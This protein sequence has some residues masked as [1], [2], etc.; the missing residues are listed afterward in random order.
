MSNF[1][2]PPAHTEQDGPMIPIQE[3]NA[4]LE[5][6]D[7]QTAQWFRA[8]YAETCRICVE[9]PASRQLMLTMLD[10]LMGTLKAGGD[11]S[12]P[13]VLLAG[14]MLQTGYTMGRRHAEAE[15]LEGWMRL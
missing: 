3:F 11:F 13:L 6:L 15:V 4:A 5:E 9:S 12:V 10:S 14:T 8:R 1:G 2:L 7:F